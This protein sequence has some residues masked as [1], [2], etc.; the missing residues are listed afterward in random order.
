MKASQ[1]GALAGCQ[2]RKNKKAKVPMQHRKN[3]DVET[4]NIN[5]WYTMGVTSGFSRARSLLGYQ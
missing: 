2:D 5:S 4:L 3:I 1:G